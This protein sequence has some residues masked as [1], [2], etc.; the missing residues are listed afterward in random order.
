MTETENI[1]TEM[2]PN[3]EVHGFKYLLKLAFRLKYWILATIM[4]ALGIVFVYLRFTPKQYL[5]T[6]KLEVNV[7]SYVPHIYEV[8]SMELFT[9]SVAER[10]SAVRENKEVEIQSEAFLQRIQEQL[11]YKVTVG[12]LKE[13][14]SVNASYSPNLL[15]LGYTSDNKG[16]ADTILMKLVELYNA[17][18]IEK[19]LR[20]VQ[21]SIDK[22]DKMLQFMDEKDSLAMMDDDMMRVFAHYA[23]REQSK[24]L[25]KEKLE[26][27]R[28]EGCVSLL[29]L[30]PALSVLEAPTGSDMPVSPHPKMLYLLA[31]VLGIM[32][33][34]V[35]AELRDYMK[36]G[37]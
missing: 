5:R 30:Q 10:L 37:R 3:E 21:S 8:D 17:Y 31:V 32:C 28:A 20:Q 23:G 25:I 26:E 36:N 7:S 24:A 35:G 14:F 4:I 19:Q 12:E 34:L 1:S 29:N 6:C 22:I 13:H 27:C 15:V 18:S 9:S 2:K 33:P 11:P 16:K